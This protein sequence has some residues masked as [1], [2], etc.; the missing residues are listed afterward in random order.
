MGEWLED[1]GAVA[2]CGMLK[3]VE[4]TKVSLLVEADPGRIESN[5]KNDARPGLPA[6]LPT[7]HAS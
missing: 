6:Q 4:E 5:F 1:G 2:C 3:K 7:L